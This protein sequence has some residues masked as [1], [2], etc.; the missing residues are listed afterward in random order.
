VSLR[1]VGAAGR[2]ELALQLA[3]APHEPPRA[4]DGKQP[5]AAEPEGLAVV[6][7]ERGRRVPQQRAH[8]LGRQ[9]AARGAEGLRADRLLARQ[10][11]S[12]AGG[13][14]PECLEHA[15]VAASIAVA[16]LVQEQAHEQRGAERSAAM[17]DAPSVHRKRSLRGRDQCC[18]VAVVCFNGVA[19]NLR[20]CSLSYQS[21]C[22]TSAG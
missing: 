7:I 22:R 15:R 20:S 16:N 10:L 13:L 21:S 19:R 5:P 8:E 18:D 3:R 14:V 2:A 12:R 9:L 17:E 6:L 1:V 11:E 4:I